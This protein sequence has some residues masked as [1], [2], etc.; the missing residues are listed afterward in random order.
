VLRGPHWSQHLEEISVTVHAGGDRT[1]APVAVERRL[2]GMQ[3]ERI[4][5]LV[6]K[7]PFEAETRYEV[8]VS[9]PHLHDRRVDR[10]FASDMSGPT[11]AE[12]AGRRTIGLR[13]I[14]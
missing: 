6:S 2:L 14:D 5:D 1:Q 10:R 13:A 4:I 12:V 8:V 11:G 9:T 7:Q 3:G